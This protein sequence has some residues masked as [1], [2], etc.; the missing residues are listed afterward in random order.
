MF[1]TIA[2]YIAA[3]FAELKPTASVRSPEEIVGDIAFI[4][5]ELD[6]AQKAR[7]TNAAKASDKVDKLD[8]RIAALEALQD[9]QFEVWATEV[10]ERNRLLEAHAYLGA[11]MKP[12]MPAEPA[13][14][15]A[16]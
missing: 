6:Y 7:L 12:F 2:T 11:V 4:R 13:P 5:D 16:E 15:E 8:D 9:E 10:D 1:K 14:T 3:R